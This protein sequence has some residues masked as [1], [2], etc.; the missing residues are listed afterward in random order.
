MFTHRI[1]W[2]AQTIFLL[3]GALMYPEPLCMSTQIE[4]IFPLKLIR[5]FSILRAMGTL[6]FSK[7]RGQKG[8]VLD[9]S[10]VTKG[11]PLQSGKT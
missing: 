1:R 4:T 5:V 6:F 8:L 9:A 7:G 10:G 11:N 3:T 2:V